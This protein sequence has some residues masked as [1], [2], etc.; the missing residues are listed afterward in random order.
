MLKVLAHNIVAKVA[1]LW[2]PSHTDKRQRLLDLLKNLETSISQT[3]RLIFSRLSLLK[4][5]K[6]TKSTKQSPRPQRGVIESLHLISVFNKM[7]T[8]GKFGHSSNAKI[9]S[10]IRPLLLYYKSKKLI[11]DL[12]KSIKMIKTLKRPLKFTRLY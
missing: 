11:S 10:L 9:Y 2:R 7:T 3:F 1:Q 8:H 12:L 5:S 4:M 6:I